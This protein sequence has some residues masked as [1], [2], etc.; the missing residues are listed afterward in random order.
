V[1]LLLLGC[2]GGGDEESGASPDT[3]QDAQDVDARVFPPT[4]LPFGKRYGEWSAEWWQWVFSIPASVHPLLDGSGEHC[5]MAQ[6][7][8]A[9]F[10]AGG[11]QIPGADTHHCAVPE[12]TALFLPIF[13]V[14]RDNIGVTPPRTETALR[15]LASADLDGVTEVRVEVDGVPIQNLDLFRFA[16]PVF[17]VTLPQNNVLQATGH[18]VAVPG[19]VFPVVAEGLYVMLKPLPAGE[20]TIAVRGSMPTTLF[21][22]DVAYQLSITPLPPIIP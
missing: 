14:E 12:G 3:G 5:V 1:L 10:L 15:R 4:A 9:W 2:S 17:S 13:T 8:P 20:H 21:T 7:G 6:R 22:L 11:T 18:A 19:T 16:S